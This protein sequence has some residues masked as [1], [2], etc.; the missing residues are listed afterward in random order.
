MGDISWTRTKWLS[1]SKD[2]INRPVLLS[3]Y[4]GIIFSVRYGLSIATQRN[5]VFSDILECIL[6]RAVINVYIRKP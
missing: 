2:R 4:S 5:S 6:S 3:S 1:K